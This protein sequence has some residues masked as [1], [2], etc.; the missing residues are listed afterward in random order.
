MNRRRLLVVIAVAAFSVALVWATLGSTRGPSAP[1]RTID[2]HL[3]R[4][5]AASFPALSLK[6]LARGAP[7]RFAG[8]WD[9]AA[10]DG[11]VTLAELRGVPVLVNFWASWCDPCQREAPRLRDGWRDANRSGVLFVGVNAEDKHDDAINFDGHYRLTYP[12]LVDPSGASLDALRATGLPETYF[13]DRAGRI[14]AH[15][16]GEMS[17]EELR[18]GIA[19]AQ[20]GEVEPPLR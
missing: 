5:E 2:E 14:V 16:V 9:R 8:I 1:A 15:V 3:A 4:G 17:R 10:G 19:A 6:V 13:L 11:R 20:S 7:G 18:A 12:N